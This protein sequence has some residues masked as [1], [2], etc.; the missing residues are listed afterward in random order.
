[1]DEARYTIITRQRSDPDFYLLLGPF[2]A[3]RA[4]LR[5]MGALFDD[6]DKRWFLAID[7][8]HAV[9]GFAALLIRP[10]AFH[11]CSAYV[12]PAYRRQ[13]IYGALID[14]RLA[15][16]PAGSSITVRANAHSGKAYLA[17]GFAVKRHIGRYTD[18]EYTHG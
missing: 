6:A 3:N 14:A 8:Q 12:L 18:L 7:T 15:A 4:V 10:H 1:M 9:V 2:L 13:G 17:R 11:C 5:E 16:C